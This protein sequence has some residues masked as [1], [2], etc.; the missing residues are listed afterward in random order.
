M[1]CYKG[2]RLITDQESRTVSQSHPMIESRYKS[3]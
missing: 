3:Q 1:E 2:L